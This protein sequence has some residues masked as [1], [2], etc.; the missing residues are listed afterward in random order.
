MK[1]TLPKETHGIHVA[2]IIFQ[3]STLLELLGRGKK[4]EKTRQK[5]KKKP[6]ASETNE[7][8]KVFD[9][10]AQGKVELLPDGGC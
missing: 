4:R 5:E 7:F 6:P 8:R 1:K 10:A 9:L 2:R 3:Q